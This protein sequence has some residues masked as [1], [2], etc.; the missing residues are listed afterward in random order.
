MT[1]NLTHFS[2]I[3]ADYDAFVLDLW[4]VIHDG[5]VM[6]PSA[7]DCLAELHAAG[8]RVVFLSN[9]PRRAAVAEA[10][11]Q[12]FGIPRAQ[13]EHVITSGEVAH[14]WVAGGK[15]KH[16]GDRCVFIGLEA[17]LP[18]LTGLSIERVPHP[19]Q[20]DF[21]FCA[22]YDYLFQPPQDQETRLKKCLARKLP[23][24]CVNPDYEVV[25]QDGSVIYC[26]GHLARRYE[27]LG[28]TVT[29][30]GKP[31]KI[32]YD[33]VF[34]HFAD[35]PRDRILAVGDS[36][37]TDIAGANQAGIASALITGGILQRELDA[38][39]PLAELC[40]RRN[41]TPDFVLPAFR[42]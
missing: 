11:L 20:A 33:A 23:M 5:V 12:R 9:A 10:G 17:D 30:I 26:A 27:E 19:D 34:D 8:K 40:R 13:F 1:K 7:A 24:L 38:G 25:R 15:A 31:H 14:H 35:M 21:V 2:A 32:V 41:A 4:G 3:A 22:G 18:V 36:L 29:Y 6:Y 28:G 39:V 16:L 37:H 42:W